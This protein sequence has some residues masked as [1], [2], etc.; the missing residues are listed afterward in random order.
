MTYSTKSGK[1][2]HL[3][4]KPYSNCFAITPRAIKIRY[5]E[6]VTF[7]STIYRICIRSIVQAL[8]VLASFP[9][10]LILPPPGARAER[11]WSG[12]VTCHLDSR[13]HEGGVLCNQQLVTISFVE[14]KG[15]RCDRH[16]PQRFKNN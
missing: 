6:L 7:R 1:C 8:Q 5:D 15:S 10:S 4:R 16:Y 12:L 13:E 9:G 3:T 2:R 14:F 11:P